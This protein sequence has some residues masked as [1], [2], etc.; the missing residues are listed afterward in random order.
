MSLEKTKT[1]RVSSGD[2]TYIEILT[3]HPFEMQLIK[4]I[5]HKWRFGDIVIMARDGL[6]YRLRRVE[7]F[8]D[9]TKPDVLFDSVNMV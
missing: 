1:S 7:E 3:L 2:T 4:A 5:R 8:I 9:L 6:P